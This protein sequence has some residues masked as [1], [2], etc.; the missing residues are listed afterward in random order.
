M[1]DEQNNPTQPPFWQRPVIRGA[2]NGVAFSILLL[3]M[4]TTGVF[5]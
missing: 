3:L 2:I 1:T 4:Q 5:Q